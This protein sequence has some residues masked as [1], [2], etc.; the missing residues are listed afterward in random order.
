MLYSPPSGGTPW[1]EEKKLVILPQH[2]FHLLRSFCPGRCW[3]GR[4]LL[5]FAVLWY[6]GKRVNDQLRVI[7]SSFLPTSHYSPLH[8]RPLLP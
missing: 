4:F 3:G 6:C 8:Q 7:I 2:C 5:T 1:R